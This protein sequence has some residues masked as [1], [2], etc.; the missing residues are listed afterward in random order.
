[1]RVLVVGDLHGDLECVRNDVIP[2][3]LAR[4]CD[5]IMQL[6]DF[7]F[8]WDNSL[9]RSYRKLWSLSELLHAHGLTL[10]FLP[11]NHENHSVLRQLAAGVPHSAEGHAELAPHIYY[12][13]RMA[14]WEWNGTRIAAVGGAASI[15]RKFREIGVSWWPEEMLTDAEVQDAS[16]L[17]AVDVLFTHDA[18]TCLPFTYL[19]EDEQSARSRESMDTIARALMPGLWLHGHYHDYA[20]YAFE[21]YTDCSCMV[22][23]L[24]CNGAP[25]RKLMKIVDFTDYATVSV[26]DIRERSRII[27]TE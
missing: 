22:I 4:K 18:P 8:V 3:A 26:E 21:H 25:R 7:G 24:D 11:G 16:R 10:H 20:E 12:T 17:G 5:V 15:D 6:G 9:E 27:R 13:G 2:V 14:R 1:M 23:A 19:V